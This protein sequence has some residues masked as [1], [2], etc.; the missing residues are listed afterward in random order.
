MA[1]PE[2]KYPQVIKE[3]RLKVPSYRDKD[4]TFIGSYLNAD[5]TIEENGFAGHH[6]EESC[7]IVCKAYNKRVGY[8]DEKTK[9]IIKKLGYGKKIKK[10]KGKKDKKPKN[11]KGKKGKKSKS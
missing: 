1:K 11:K 10:D 2:L 6:T 3:E 4:E 9:E 5:G 7:W 8:S